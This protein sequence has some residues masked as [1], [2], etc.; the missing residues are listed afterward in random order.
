MDLET[1]LQRME[2]NGWC[3]LEDI[4]PDGAVEAVRDSILSTIETHSNPD[5]RRSLGK[6][7]GLI[8][9][10][11]SFAPYLAAPPL[12]DLCK[13]LLGEHVRV[14]FTTCMTTFPGNERGALHADWPFNQLNASHIP[15]PYADGVAHLTTIWML[16][17]FTSKNG[18]TPI[19][20][21]SHRSHNNPS[22]D[23]GVDMRVP[24]ATEMQV[25]GKAGSVLVMDSRLWHAIGANRAQE[26]RVAV[27]VRFAPWWLNLDVLRPDSD[28]RKR[29]VEEPGLDENLVPLVP[30]A[31][32]DELADA[33]KPLF[34]HWVQK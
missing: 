28:E 14:S 6:I 29:I 12:L 1:T 31:V 10:D 16:T 9:H 26:A 24:Y 17:P 23:L 8:N 32:F 34:R 33:V 3:V 25:T 2:V 7:S 19:V 30:A 21:G 15:A 20:S 13:A 11:Q 18:G 22:G 4:I 5:P 27:V